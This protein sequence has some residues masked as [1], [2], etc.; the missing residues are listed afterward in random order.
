MALIIYTP[1]GNDIFG[2]GPLPA[3]IFGPLMCGALVLLLAEE[4]RKFIAGSIRQRRPFETSKKAGS[5]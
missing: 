1:I 3:W 5:P 4:T 2:T